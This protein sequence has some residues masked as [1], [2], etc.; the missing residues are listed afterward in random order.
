M[1]ETNTPQNLVKASIY[2]VFDEKAGPLP[3]ASC[4]SSFPKKTAEEIAYKSMSFSSMSEGTPQSLAVL[5]IPTFNLKGLVKNIVFNHPKRRG[6][7]SDCCIVLV[8]DEHKDSIFYK[9]IRQFETVFNQYSPQFIAAEQG[10]DENVD[11]RC[12]ELL[13]AFH[14]DVVALIADLSKAEPAPSSVAFPRSDVDGG[15]G[16]NN[17]V[18]FKVVVAGDPE[19]GKTSMILNF[20]EKAFRRVYIPTIGVNISEK[21]IPIKTKRVEFVIWDIAGQ[22]KFEKMRKHLYEGAQALLLVFDLTRPDTLKS[23]PDWHADIVKNQQAGIIVALAGNKADLVAARKVGQEGVNLASKLG[24]RYIETSALTGQN[25]IDTFTC[26]G[27]QLLER[28]K[29]E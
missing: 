21:A 12:L 9:Y 13:E 10:T 3:R 24:V 29:F 26:I 18:R 25:I 8:F 19:V 4:P 22:S 11:A 16:E 2:A 28:Y 20:S 6:G 7:K 15:G 23:I 27:E 5:P 1:A 17:K 14:A